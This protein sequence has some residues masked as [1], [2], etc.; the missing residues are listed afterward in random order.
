MHKD[1]L[2]TRILRCKEMIIEAISELHGN[3]TKTCEAVGISRPTYYDYLQDPVFYEAVTKARHEGYERRKDMAEQCLEDQ[4]KN[5]NTISTIFF[6]KTQARDRGYIENPPPEQPSQPQLQTNKDGIKALLDDYFSN[7]TNVTPIEP[8]QPII[9]ITDS[10]SHTMPKY[11]NSP[12]TW[13]ICI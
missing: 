2:E 6:L 3:I 11:S 12:P 5:G 8:S 1:N 10:T 9:T 13:Y 7:T 4:I